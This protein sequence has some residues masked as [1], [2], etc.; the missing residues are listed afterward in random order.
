LQAKS[1]VAIKI[2]GEDLDV[3]F[4]KAQ[5]VAKKIHKVNGIADM[6]VQQIDGVPQMVVTITDCP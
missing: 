6:K 2:F 5:E 4:E 3:L 1:D